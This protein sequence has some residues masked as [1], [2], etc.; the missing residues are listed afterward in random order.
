MREVKVCAREGVCPHCE[1]EDA[2]EISEWLL[3]VSAYKE[4]KCNSCH[5]VYVIP[6]LILFDDY[7]PKDEMTIELA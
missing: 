1:G 3:E 4:V 2:S 7:R 5:K 6:Y